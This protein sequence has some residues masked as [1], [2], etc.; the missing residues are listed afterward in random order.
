MSN[1]QKSMMDYEMEALAKKSNVRLDLF[2]LRSEA[3][4]LSKYVFN[5]E[6]WKAIVITYVIARKCKKI[7]KLLKEKTTW[8]K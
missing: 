2:E 4:A 8:Q 3:S 6:Y 5:N 1:K 7:R